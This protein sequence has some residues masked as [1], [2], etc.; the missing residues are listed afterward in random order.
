VSTLTFKLPS[1]A[2]INWSLRILGKRLDGYHEVRTILQTVS[3]H[4]V[5][6]FSTSE[7]GEV[8]LSCDDPQIP[9]GERNLIVRAA[10]T[11]R[12]RFGIKEG[13]RVH[14]EKQIPSAGGLG[15][16]SSNAAV[17]LLGLARLWELRANI[18]ELSEIA[19][20]LGADVPFFLHGG[21]A[22]ATGT[23]TTIFP[24]AE[25]ETHYLLIATPQTTVSTAAAYA[26]YQAL[27]SHALTTLESDSILAISRE[28]ADPGNSDQGLQRN[29]LTNDFEQVIF[30]IE[31]E[32][33]R[34]KEALIQAGAGDALLA[35]SGSSVFGVFRSRE[36][37]Q[38][39]LQ[40]IQ[41]ES[42]WRM[43]SCV[44]LSRDEYQRL[45]GLSG[46]RSYATSN[47][48]SNTGA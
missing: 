21:R 29:H 25:V 43:F 1:F 12:N 3:L 26:A 48:V 46:I 10:H 39:A 34:A 17:A 8:A 40:E 2:K 37:Q 35:G 20:G 11:L 6:H 13:T 42:G 28:E 19:A 14:L 32:I 4:D 45:M 15:G 30:D 23:G 36:A 22:L 16:G 24:V 47:D 41:T 7:N 38:R 31:P 27:Q 9:T 18:A 33:K 5:L 44:T